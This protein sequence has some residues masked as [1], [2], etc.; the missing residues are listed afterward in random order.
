MLDGACS[1]CGYAVDWVRSAYR[2]AWT[3]PG[4]NGPQ[5]VSAEYMFAP[6]DTPGY[7]F[8]HYFGSRNWRKNTRVSNVTYGE[9]TDAKQS[10]SNGVGFPDTPPATLLP[11]C[12]EQIPAPGSPACDPTLIVAPYVTV[13]W[14][15]QGFTYQFSL[16]VG[17]VN[18]SPVGFA[19]NFVGFQRV[20]T[21]IFGGGPNSVSVND[22]SGS[23]CGCPFGTLG[24]AVFFAQTF[25]G[26]FH[27]GIGSGSLDFWT[28]LTLFPAGTTSWPGPQRFTSTMTL[29]ADGGDVTGEAVLTLTPASEE[30][31]PG[32]VPAVPSQDFYNGFPTSCW[33]KSPG[34]FRAPWPFSPVDTDWRR[35]AA[36]VLCYQYSSPSTAFSKVQAY[37]GESYNYF[38]TFNGPGTFP[39][40]IIAVN[41]ARCIVFV[42][43]T[44]NFYQLSVQ[45]AQ[46]V[47]PPANFGSYRTLPLWDQTTTQ[48][49]TMMT[50]AGV[51]PSGEVA[52]VGHSYGGAV[53][54]L[55]AYRLAR[56]MPNRR[57]LSLLTFGAPPIGDL[58]PRGFPGTSVVAS[59]ICNVGDP[60]GST[61]PD[62]AYLTVL[63][64][65]IPL[66]TFAAWNG[67]KKPRQ[68]TRLHTDGTFQPSDTLTLDEHDLVVVLNGI[69]AGGVLAVPASHYMAEY[70]KRLWFGT[71][72]VDSC[73]G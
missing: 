25:N 64:P 32:P 44:T 62:V 66:A 12:P 28:A 24:T 17:Y 65:F 22:Y 51:N 37:L 11:V 19:A 67:W 56:A 50:E 7:P 27:P 53:A 63:L 70:V 36:G 48:L 57:R 61:P 60:V 52:I 6:D 3:V 30:V 54:Q 59:L 13:Q 55:A 72:N 5:R 46:A 73:G 35:F 9:R 26:G 10:W 23:Q 58:G 45:A 21:V 40:V 47:E 1:P 69:L 42:S 15:W 39:G 43:G 41:P 34:P 29:R 18:G 8:G 16:R 33:P 49:L 20:A 71:P 68:T 38:S 4:A 31:L 2:S 14:A